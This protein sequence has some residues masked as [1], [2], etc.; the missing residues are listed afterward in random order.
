MLEDHFGKVPETGA[1]LNKFGLEFIVRDIADEHIDKIEIRS[2]EAA[3]E[4][5]ASQS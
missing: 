5:R 3:L 1:A 4:A 2:P